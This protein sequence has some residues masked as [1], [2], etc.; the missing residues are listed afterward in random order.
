MRYLH[1]AQDAK[2]WISSIKSDADSEGISFLSQWYK[3]F[4]VDDPLGTGELADDSENFQRVKELFKFYHPDGQS[5]DSDVVAHFEQYIP[6]DKHTG[7]I[8]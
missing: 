1:T 6:A 2:D 4:P 7:Y 5:S 3:Y 8:K